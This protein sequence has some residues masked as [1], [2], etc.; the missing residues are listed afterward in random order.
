MSHIDLSFSLVGPAVIP[1][2]HG[3]HL[4]AALSRVL[5]LLHETNGIAVHPIRG[6]QIGD[7]QMSL[8]ERS[9]LVLRC[10]ADHIGQ[11][12]ALA[13]KQLSIAGRSI[14]VGVPQVFALQPA[15]ALRSRL[16]TIKGFLDAEPFLAAIRRQLDDLSVSTAA[17][18]TLSRR[19]TLCIRDKEVV[20]HETIVEA[21]T[22][23]ESL[24]IQER[25][26]GGRRHMGCGVF[27]PL[28]QR[29]GGGL[30]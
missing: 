21:L 15:P 3:Y 1:A 25:G 5:P 12:L 2:D 11:L 30:D 26:L 17:E 9:R 4:Y 24:A 10:D 23:E 27:V 13:G 16:V 18:I 28:A 6:L 14:R 29:E 7:R 20:G 8:T 22:A 19:R